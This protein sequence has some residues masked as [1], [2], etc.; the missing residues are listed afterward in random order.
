[1]R[2]AKVRD[3]ELASRLTLDWP[4]AEQH[5]V[6]MLSAMREAV[7][8]LSIQAQA[9]GDV[10]TSPF[11]LVTNSEWSPQWQT[12][13]EREAG[14]LSVAASK[15]EAAC[16][17]FSEA[18]G[19]ASPDRSTTR[20]D[21][22]CE[23]ARLLLDSY[24]KPT[25]AYALEANGME[26]IGDLK[27]AVG[28]LKAY[29]EAWAALSCAYEPLAWRKINGED[30]GRR[31]AEAETCW[32][33]KRLFVR[34][35]ILKEMRVNGAEGKPDPARD[36]ATLIRLRQEGEAIDRL[37]RQLSAFDEWH[38]H[39][40][41]PSS[42]ESLRELGKR[43]HDGTGK[44]ADEVHGLAGLRE[45]IRNLLRDGNHLL[46]PEGGIGRKTATFLA[47]LGELQQATTAFE[48]IAGA[49]V[50]EEFASS[51]HALARLRET[52]ENIS[53]RHDELRGWCSWRKRRDEAVD[54]DLLSLVEAVEQGRIPAS[55]IREIFEAAYCTW[56]SGAIIGADE[57]LRNFS[58]PEQ[59]ATIANFQKVDDR[60]Q[61]TTARY[62]AARLA[63]KLPTQGAV[64]KSSEWGILRHELQKKK[65]HKPIRKLLEQAPE[66]LTALAP[67]FMMSPLSVAQY[68]PPGQ[69]LFDVVIFDEASQITVWDAIGAIARGRQVIVAG[70]PKQMPPTN[71]F[72]RSE[73]DPDGDVDTEGDLESILDEMLGAGIPE[74]TLNL[75]YRSRKES[76]IAFS[77]ERYYDNSLVTFPAPDVNDRAVSLVRPE[78]FYARGGAR[79]NE[80]E[81][82]AIV[83]EVVRRLRHNDPVVRTQSIGVVTFNAEQQTLIEN[84]LDEAR[85]E[86]PEIEPAFSSANTLEPVFVKN[87]ETVQGDERDV[88]LFSVTY[89]PDRN[90]NVTMNFG[91]LN[92]EGGER[93][94]NVALTRARSE[95]IVFSTLDPDRVDLSRTQAQAVSDLKHFLQYAERG[96]AALAAAVSGPAADF[97]SPFETAVAEGIAPERLAG[98]SP[99]SA[100][101]TIGLIWASCTLTNPGA[102]SPASSTTARCTTVPRSHGNATKSADRSSRGSAGR[103]SASGPPTGGR[104]SPRPSKRWIRSYAS[105]SKSTANNGPPVPRPPEPASECGSRIGYSRSVLHRDD[106][107]AESGIAP[108]GYRVEAG[109]FARGTALGFFMSTRRPGGAS[110]AICSPRKQRRFFNEIRSMSRPVAS[111]RLVSKHPKILRP[112][113]HRIW[114]GSDPYPSTP[115]SSVPS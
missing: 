48:D 109:Y 62:V 40:T 82:K 67:C 110:R 6:Q 64:K 47:A 55:E 92:R 61:E 85:S 106:G 108:D 56:W 3:E 105:I 13:V 5:D 50:W 34:R 9:I 89:G 29:R 84:L 33:P 57:V 74:Q 60:F 101:Q 58:T 97:E 8:N 93:R 88:I 66:A 17:A 41:D 42:V 14:S 26:Q 81:A 54:A 90:G 112:V 22:L 94:L 68:L 19:I 36:A 91:P 77:N 24:R 63:R 114:V 87:L 43:A 31:W 20:L 25:T 72:A 38:E 76:L 46:A 100:F 107:L 98:A 15:G 80:G 102:I 4:S 113:R 59:T 73:D 96:R 111:R 65:R 104:T 75:H 16:R 7:E 21:T 10:T 86:K 1:M 30:I 39:E 2:W 83:A 51:D 103:C 11:H 37:D 70:D 44:L 52:A 23:L 28:R 95:M 115:V 79:H 71:F 49:S 27:E 53:T 99:R 12:Y 78:G 18:V 35:G 32:W 69:A 45:Q